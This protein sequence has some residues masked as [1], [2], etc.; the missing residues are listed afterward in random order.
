MAVWF[1]R[2]ADVCRIASPSALRL[3]GHEVFFCAGCGL[4]GC[5]P[6]ALFDLWKLNLTDCHDSV[7]FQKKPK[8]FD[9]SFPLIAQ[10]GFAITYSK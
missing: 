2:R 8:T 3:R 10:L 4:V 1:A 5:F 6:Y 7:C 9:L